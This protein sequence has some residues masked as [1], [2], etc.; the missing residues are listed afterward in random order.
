MNHHRLR[1]PGP[2]GLAIYTALGLGA[3]YAPAA[4][5]VP[6]ALQAPTWSS[7]CGQDAS[8]VAHPRVCNYSAQPTRYQMSFVPL[9]AGTYPLGACDVAGPTSF[10]LAEAQPVLIPAG[11]CVD[12]S[13]NIDRPAGMSAGQGACY[14]IEARD[15]GSDATYHAQAAFVHNGD[16]CAA[17]NSG[18]TAGLPEG[19]TVPMSFTVY[20]RGNS[21]RNFRYQV[22]S[23]ADGDAPSTVS[24]NDGAP[25]DSITG[26]R[27]IPAGGQTVI[28]MT[29]SMTETDTS[30]LQQILLIDRDSDAVIATRSFYAFDSTAPCQA[31]DTTLCLNG[32]RFEVRTLWRDFEGQ[33][34]VGRTG[35]LTADTGYF[36]F[37]NPNNIEVVLK[38]LD[39]RNINDYWWIF[40]GA[41]SN[42]EYTL[43]VRDTWTGESRSYY[44]PSGVMA[45]KGDISGLP[46]YD[47]EPFETLTGE[48]SVARALAESPL[49]AATAIEPEPQPAGNCVPSNT[50][51]CVQGG[52]FK[53]EVTWNTIAGQTG[54]GRAQALTSETGTFW[55]FSPNN[56]ELVVKVL[57]GNAINGY[58][59]VFYG[60]LSDVDY[61]ITVTDTVTGVPRE[62]HNRQGRMASVG[63][64]EAF[65]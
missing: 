19:H 32:G 54:P 28:A 43:S 35:M 18:T 41:L 6:A 13:L 53:V 24:L 62:Y 34:G 64:I 55:F 49:A 30:E 27:P 3:V 23:L 25:G 1:L 47:P 9:P 17:P 58:W 21:E 29:V 15:V 7:S 63:D 46:G 8:V 20:N 56:I 14:G 38:V 31:N 60:A 36:W 50:A 42:V 10:S 11:T 51:L 4:H 33:T 40:F 61:T 2:A 16:V 12:L 39:G 26:N 37:F 48:L 44:N 57:D 5:A 52:R 45:S 59:W 22:V 65:E